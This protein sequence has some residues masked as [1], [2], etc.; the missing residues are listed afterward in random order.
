MYI[1]LTHQQ[2]LCLYCGQ[3]GH[4]Y[5][6]CPS[7]THNQNFNNNYNNSGQSKNNCNNNNSNSGANNTNNNLSNACQGNVQGNNQG[8]FGCSMFML[9]PDP[10]AMNPPADNPSSPMGMGKQ[11]SRRVGFG[12]FPRFPPG[13]PP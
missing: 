1:S 9:S 10:S 4:R 13:Y 12:S 7:N 5:N 11:P 3:S 8:A 6:D 2:N